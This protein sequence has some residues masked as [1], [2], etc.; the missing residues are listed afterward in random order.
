MVDPWRR[1]RLAHAPWGGIGTQPN[2]SINRMLPMSFTSHIRS[3]ART[4]CMG[5]R[6]LGRVGDA[7]HL[8]LPRE[9][10]QVGGQLYRLLQHLMVAGPSAKP[11][12]H[13]PFRRG[14]DEHRRDEGSKSTKAAHAA[15]TCICRVDLHDLHQNQTVGGV[16]RHGRLP[17]QIA[18]T[19]LAHRR[20][21]GA[22][23]PSTR[24]RQVSPTTSQSPRR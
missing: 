15:R 11:E 1:T 4:S 19:P 9:Q 14:G 10:E 18:A 6:I 12:A 24:M 22:L 16:H 5:Q 17:K 7:G 23:K 21:R 8:Q 20:R 13:V 3:R 2:C